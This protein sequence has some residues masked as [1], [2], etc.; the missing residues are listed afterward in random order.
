MASVRVIPSPGPEC[1]PFSRAWRHPPWDRPYYLDL[2]GSPRTVLAH[3][4]ARRR[5]HGGSRTDVAGAGRTPLSSESCCRI[6][7]IGVA[8]LTHPLL[9]RFRRLTVASRTRSSGDAAQTPCL[10]ETLDLPHPSHRLYRMCGWRC[11]SLRVPSA[12][13]RPTTRRASEVPLAS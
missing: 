12:T 13:S 2:E 1:H 3:L 10:S 7:R 8:W 5:C 6:D 4:A 11:R 9:R